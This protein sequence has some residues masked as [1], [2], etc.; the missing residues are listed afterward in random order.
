MASDET[1]QGFAN[2]LLRAGVLRQDIVLAF[3]PPSCA[4]CRSFRQREACWQIRL[5]LPANLIHDA[6]IRDLA[7]LRQ[8]K[9]LAQNH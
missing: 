1:D 3:H 7:V 6:G 8:E 9:R 4:A 2:V 5:L